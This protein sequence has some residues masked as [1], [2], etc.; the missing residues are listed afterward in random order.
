ML[1]LRSFYERNLVRLEKLS[2]KK[3]CVEQHVN[4][5]DHKNLESFKLEFNTSDSESAQQ[6]LTF[7]I[8]SQVYTNSLV[9]VVNETKNDDTI[10]I[11]DFQIY[12]ENGML[13][14]T[15]LQ[16]LQIA[17]CLIVLC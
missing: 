15:T 14:S 1:S 4:L 9:F 10:Q 5:C 11:E 13:L 17:L 12:G 8:Q 7:D 2:R 16:C 3:I 6:E